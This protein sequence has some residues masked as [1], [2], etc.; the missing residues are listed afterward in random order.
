[1]HAKN[2]ISGKVCYLRQQGFARGSD[3]VAK[4]LLSSFSKYLEEILRARANSVAL[5]FDRKG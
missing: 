3:V 4:S 1:M 5:E 2:W